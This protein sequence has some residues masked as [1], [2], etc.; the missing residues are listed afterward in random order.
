MVTVYRNIRIRVIALDYIY[1][2]TL[3]TLLVQNASQAYKLALTTYNI[4]AFIN[5]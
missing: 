3:C 1:Y 5:I 2:I 4:Y